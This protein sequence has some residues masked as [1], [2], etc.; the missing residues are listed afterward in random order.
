MQCKL[1][2]HDIGIFHVCLSVCSHEINFP[3][4]LNFI[5][6]WL[7]TRWLHQQSLFYRELV[8]IC[9]HMTQSRLAVISAIILLAG[10]CN[11]SD[12]VLI[13]TTLLPRRPLETFR[14]AKSLTLCCTPEILIFQRERDI[15]GFDWSEIT[16]IDPVF[17]TQ[18]TSGSQCL[19]CMQVKYT[20]H[21]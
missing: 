20:W 16:C 7:Q 15:R 12:R 1:C 4:R 3:R 11:R 14:E 9:S 6:L 2:V 18:T 21:I 13:S 19:A 8:E 10:I 5:T 17:C